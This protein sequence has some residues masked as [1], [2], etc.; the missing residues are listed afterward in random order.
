MSKKKLRRV[1]LVLVGVLLPAGAF[2]FGYF[3]KQDSI[4]T[5]TLGNTLVVNGEIDGT[6]KDANL[7]TT[8]LVPGDSIDKT[9]Q[10]N[11]K[12]TAPS[13]LR[14]KVVTYWAGKGEDSSNINTKF[15]IKYSNDLKKDSTESYWYK[16]KTDGY[17]YYMGIIDEKNTEIDLV[18]GFQLETGNNVNE[19]QG[20]NIKVK[21]D[22]DLIQAKHKVYSTKWGDIEKNLEV[23][24]D[25]LCDGITTTK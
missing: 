2:G 7:D 4:P 6:L 18:E 12:C 23:E 21:V 24:L 19:Y 25:K 3:L 11:P 16:D 13:L 10:I 9:I 22:L 1:T 15:K 20:K 14:V 17:L 8:G 5:K